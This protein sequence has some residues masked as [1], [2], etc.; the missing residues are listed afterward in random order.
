MS[1]EPTAEKRRA[2]TDWAVC[3]AGPRKRGVRAKRNYGESG[4]R[5]GTAADPAGKGIGRNSTLSAWRALAAHGGAEGRRERNLEAACREAVQAGG[6][7]VGLPLAA[8]FEM[9]GLV[10]VNGFG[11]EVGRKPEV[12]GAAGRKAV[13]MD[14]DDS[15]QH[16]RQHEGCNE[17]PPWP[18]SGHKG[19]HDS[20]SASQPPKRALRFRRSS[21]VYRKAVSRRSAP[22]SPFLVR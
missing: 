11:R 15:R 22:L 9:A 18:R 16:E 8:F 14:L 20:S 2:G 3:A 1:I 6:A 10:G 7:L 13:V 19:P 12:G 4:E 17:P 21:A 5:W